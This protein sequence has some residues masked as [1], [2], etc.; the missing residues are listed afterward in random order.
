MGFKLSLE[1]IWL[2]KGGWYK[3]NLYGKVYISHSSI[4]K[5]EM[6]FMMYRAIYTTA[7]MTKSQSKKEKDLQTLALQ[8][9]KDKKLH[10]TL[11][12]MAD[13]QNKNMHIT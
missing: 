12:Y 5:L 9:K 6:M 1:G 10:R 13:S 4:T 2:K 11:N 7:N 3:I 8:L